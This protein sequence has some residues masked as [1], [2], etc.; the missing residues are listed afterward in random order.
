MLDHPGRS[1]GTPFNP[2][3]RAFK[4]GIDPTSIR[5]S[6]GCPVAPPPFRRLLGACALEIP[7]GGEGPIARGA[8]GDYHAPMNLILLFVILL[9]LF[10]GGGFYFGGPAIGGGGLGLI[11]L[12][13]LIVFLAGG[14][15]TKT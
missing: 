12:I 13:C 8:P 3:R 5:P 9:L 4:Y 6:C 15:R 10:G 2:E 14:F 11:L 1:K 7:G